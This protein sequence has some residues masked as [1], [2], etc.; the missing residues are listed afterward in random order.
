[1]FAVA[2]IIKR[3]SKQHGRMA[4]GGPGLPKVSLQPA[5]PDPSTSCW[6]G[7]LRSSSTPLD[8]HRRKPMAS[9]VNR[10][11]GDGF[12]KVGSNAASEDEDGSN[13]PVRQTMF[14][15]TL[16]IDSN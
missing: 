11:K 6:A 8:T 10:G 16:L 5:K 13:A 14:E 4:R 2:G 9:T 1:V 7:G 3:H 15:I 12:G